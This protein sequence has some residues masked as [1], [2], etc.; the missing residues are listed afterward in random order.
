MLGTGTTDKSPLG[1]EVE[2]QGQFE[3]SIRPGWRSPVWVSGQLDWFKATMERSRPDAGIRFS[4]IQQ[5]QKKQKWNR[6]QSCCGGGRGSG[7][8][9]S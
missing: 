7:G 1:P 2:D 6:Q 5:Y 3:K 8:V 9:F 4:F